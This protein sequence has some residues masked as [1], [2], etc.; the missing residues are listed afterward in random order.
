M[1]KNFKV[2]TTS[3]L[4]IT[5]PLNQEQEEA[6]ITENAAPADIPE[7]YK[8]VREAK[9]ERLQ[10]LVRPSVHEKLKRIAAEQGTSKNEIINKL[11]EDYLQGVE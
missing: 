8:L 6:P 9:T 10:L 2:Q 3:E 4:F 5:S 7:G 11:I 1:A